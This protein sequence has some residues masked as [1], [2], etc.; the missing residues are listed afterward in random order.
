[1]SLPTNSLP[2]YS[3]LSEHLTNLLSSTP[4]CRV[5]LRDGPGVHHKPRKT[6]AHELI[7]FIRDPSIQPATA[8]RL[9]RPYL[10]FYQL[11][12][13]SNIDFC[14]DNVQT[15]AIKLSHNCLPVGILERRCGAATDACPKCIQPETVPH[16]YLCTFGQLGVANS[17]LRLRSTSK[18][19]QLQPTF[20]VPL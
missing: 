13:L 7:P 18:T 5:Y 11:D 20:D 14:A 4:A 2:M 17:S 8:Q 15:F 12:C 16:L 3:R 9:D 6:H 19:H 1:M 10:C